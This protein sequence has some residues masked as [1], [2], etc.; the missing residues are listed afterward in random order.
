MNNQLELETYL[1]RSNM[2]IAQKANWVLRGKP[3]SVCPD[4]QCR[5]EMSSPGR[6]GVKL[7]LPSCKY[8]LM[9]CTF[10]PLQWKEW[11]RF[12][13]AELRQLDIEHAVREG[14]IS[15][16]TTPIITRGA[17]TITETIR[18]RETLVT[19]I[20]TET[21]KTIRIEQGSLRE[22]D[23]ITI[24]PSFFSKNDAINCE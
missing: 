19:I 18:I 2:S 14:R 10:N 16:E 17:P 4:C 6:M 22:S 15:G 23:E 8:A 9:P 21:R 7:C 5:G 13:P 20:T 24:S 11:L 12:R 1:R 3:Y